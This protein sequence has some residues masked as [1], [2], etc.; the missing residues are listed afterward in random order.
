MTSVAQT[1]YLRLKE[2]ITGRQL[3]TGAPI[4]EAL[5]SK[6]LGVGRGPPSG[7]TR[8]TWRPWSPPSTT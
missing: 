7:A 3:A 6:L 2:K 8:R 1:A 4:T 5:V